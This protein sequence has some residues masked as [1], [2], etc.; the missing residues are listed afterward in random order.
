MTIDLLP[1]LAALVGGELPKHKIDGKDIWPLMSG[2]RKAKSPHEVLFFYYQQGELQALR[3]GRWKLQLPH[4]YRTLAGAPG[5]D[6]KPARYKQR[7]TGRELYDLAKDVSETKDVA[8]LHPDVV[9]R[10]EAM[11]EECREDLGDSLTK[12]QGR[13][14]RAPGRLEVD[15]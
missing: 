13:N 9:K 15:K 7:Q 11:V 6:G 1:T 2:K 5:M 14:V 4:E 3:S 12:R 8:H 10:L